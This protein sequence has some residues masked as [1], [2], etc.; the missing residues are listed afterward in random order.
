MSPDQKVLVQ[1]SWR[2]LMPK[3]ESL[4][5]IFYHRLFVTIPAT[6][7]MFAH[8][9]PAA[10]VKKLIVAL[11]TVVNGL[12]ELET[13]APAL[14]ALGRRHAS[15]GVEDDQY[16]AVR[17]VLLWTLK[18]VLGANWTNE[19]SVAWSEAYPIVAQVMREAG[20]PSNPSIGGNPSSQSNQEE[21]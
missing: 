16:D 14:T 2:A 9:D 12:Y 15:Y 5:Y 19:L 7:T 3:A 11:T 20:S 13:L 4:A 10:Q 1:R 6:R 8:V 18:T 17:E 21:A